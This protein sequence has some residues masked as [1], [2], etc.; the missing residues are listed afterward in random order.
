MSWI[1]LCEAMSAVGTFRTSCD[2]RLES[3]IHFKADIV[4]RRT[5]PIAPAF[6]FPNAFWQDGPRG[7]AL[8]PPERV[9]ISHNESNGPGNRR[10]VKGGKIPARTGNRSRSL[11]DRLMGRFQK[12]LPDI[13][14]QKTQGRPSR[15]NHPPWRRERGQTFHSLGKG[16]STQIGTADGGSANARDRVF[17]SCP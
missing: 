9:C 2:V 16:S 4:C 6:A 3:A 11:R 14:Q 17:S 10:K 15:R 1:N 7:S 8:A 5:S 13:R 12:I